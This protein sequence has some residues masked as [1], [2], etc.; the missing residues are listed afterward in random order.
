MKQQELGELLEYLL[1]QPGESEWIEFKHNNYSP[2][3]LGEYISAL[4][5]SAC[6][7]DKPRSY[8][9]FG[10]EDKTK[11][12][13]GTNFN[14][15]KEKVRNQEL[16]NWLDTQL[17]PSIQFTFSVFSEQKTGYQ[18]VIIEIHPALGSPIK[19]KTESY[20][21]VGTYKKKL[22]DH[23][24]LERR[25]WEKLNRKDFESQLATENISSSDVL[26]I[27]DYPSFFD[28]L[29]IPLPADRESILSKLEEERMIARRGKSCDITNLRAILYAK[30]LSYFEHLDRKSIRVIIYKGGNRNESAK[31][32][33]GL[34]GYATGFEGLISYIN[35]QIPANELIGQAIRVNTKMY[36]EIAI[37]ELVAN[38]LIHQDLSIKGSSPL[39]EIFNDRIEFSNPG[40]PLID[41]L[42]FLDHAPQ[43]RNEK[44]AKMM[45]RV[46]ICEE[47][48]SGIDKVIIQTELYQLPAPEFEVGDS[49][50]RVILFAHK[51]F[52]EMGKKDRIRAAYQ[53]SCLRYVSNQ[54]MTNES[55][56]KRFNISDKNYPIASRI[57]NEAVDAKLVKPFDLESKSRKYARYIPFWA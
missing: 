13:V 50:T 8:L 20:I 53:H 43:S 38:T 26:R 14:P 57:I 30:K 21:R 1:S 7:L 56:R 6:L 31:E 46:G 35:D 44:I 54:Q 11:K 28:M 37:R 2:D 40:K 29:N 52:S 34:K 36:P 17:R 24:G 25:L 32:Q 51:T 15:N 16:L 33:I 5:N 4:S 42:R 10:I 22:R 9:I 19:F 49:F 18:I 39:I 55:L 23:A 12:V 47:R 27:I 3:D 45:R 41:T 48:G